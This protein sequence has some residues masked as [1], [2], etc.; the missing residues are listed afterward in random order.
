MNKRGWLIPIAIVAVNALA[1]ICCWKSLPD[2]L[3]AHYDLQGNPD[4]V[5]QRGVLSIYPL[6]G[7]VICLAAYMIARIKSSLQSALI[8]LTSGVCLV[9]LSSSLVSLTFGKIPLFMLA[10]PVILLIAVAASVISILKSR[11]QNK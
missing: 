10:E 7:A 8:I 5:M 3:P 4:G 1:I 11:K 9:I 6:I 2:P